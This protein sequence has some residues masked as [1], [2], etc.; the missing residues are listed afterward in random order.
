MLICTV[1]ICAILI[2]LAYPMVPAIIWAPKVIWIKH[3][4]IFLLFLCIIH[5]ICVSN[6]LFFVK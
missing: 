6:T 4:L 1:T 3:M 5:P 2:I